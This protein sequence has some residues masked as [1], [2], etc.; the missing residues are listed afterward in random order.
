MPE[1]EPDW[2]EHFKKGNY[3]MALEK[4]MLFPGA[5]SDQVIALSA[6][7]TAQAIGEV[8]QQL[9]RKI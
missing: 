8:A 2:I 5:S 7:V 9:R 3:Y 1:F 6:L 4:A